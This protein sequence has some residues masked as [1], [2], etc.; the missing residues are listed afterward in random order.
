[1]KD[2]KISTLQVNNTSLKEELRKIKSTNNI[3]SEIKKVSQ[4]SNKKISVNKDKDKEKDI[5]PLISN[6]NY[7]NIKRHNK[8]PSNKSHK[9]DVSNHSN[10]NIIPNNNIISISEEKLLAVDNTADDDNNLDE[11]QDMMKKILEEN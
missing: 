5:L 8:T 4:N 10:N 6:N 2:V 11:I 9:P 3:N 1:V 7:A